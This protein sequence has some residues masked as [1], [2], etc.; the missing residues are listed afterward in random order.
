MPQLCDKC[1]WNF[2]LCNIIRWF[3][4]S[5]PRPSNIALTDSHLLN[6]NNLLVIRCS[7]VCR[8]RTLLRK[9]TVCAERHFT[10]SGTRR[11]AH[12][13]PVLRELHWLPIRERVKFKVACG[14][15]S[16]HH[17]HHHRRNGRCHWQSTQLQGQL[18]ASSTLQSIPIVPSLSLFDI[19]SILNFPTLVPVGYPF[20]A[21]L[22]SLLSL[23][24]DVFPQI[25]I[26]WRTW[27]SPWQHTFCSSHYQRF[28]MTP[29]V[30]ADDPEKQ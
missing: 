17:H 22:F 29:R 27:V 25:P 7:T 14:M 12:I 19:P 18:S 30:P 4:L 13:T 10:I 16:A 5:L 24:N 26:R 3:V 9:V 23:E 6:P 15:K 11:R 20:L 2:T 1:L 28:L 8:T 21:F